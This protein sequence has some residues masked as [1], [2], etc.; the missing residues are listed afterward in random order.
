MT[1][2]SPHFIIVSGSFWFVWPLSF[3]VFASS[4]SGRWG[5]YRG[6]GVSPPFSPHRRPGLYRLRRSGEQRLLPE[7][8][9][10]GRG[11]G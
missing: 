2:K 8:A 5:S 4:L 6:L 3:I 11:C 1:G 10:W 9:G 7:D